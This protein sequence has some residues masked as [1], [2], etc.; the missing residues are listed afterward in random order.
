MSTPREAKPRRVDGVRLRE[1]R[2][3]I[4]GVPQASKEA[5]A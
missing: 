3:V 2:R 5:E 4:A 1:G